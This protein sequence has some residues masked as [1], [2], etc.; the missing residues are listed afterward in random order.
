MT[1]GSGS[2]RTIQVPGQGRLASPGYLKDI[3]RPSWFEDG[4]LAL[5]LG[6]WG[7]QVLRPYRNDNGKSIWIIVAERCG[8]GTVQISND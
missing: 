4:R 2:S 6:A 5:I 7:E 1:P 8:A 3:C